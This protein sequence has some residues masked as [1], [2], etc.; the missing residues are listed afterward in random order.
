M[1]G[2]RICQSESESVKKPK[3]DAGITNKYINTKDISDVVWKKIF[4]YLSWK[5]IKYNVAQVCKH[6]NE[7]SNDSVQEIIIE[8]EIFSSEEIKC[9]L[10]D[11][12][13]SFKFL[14]TIKV[15]TEML[16][17]FHDVE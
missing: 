13:P 14:K 7:I 3:L 11:A 6:F 5:E 16:G 10:F 4:G 17:N 15:D 12:L 9:G 1:S 8:E 2:K